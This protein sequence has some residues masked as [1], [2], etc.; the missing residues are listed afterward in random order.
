MR[1]GDDWSRFEVEA[2]VASYRDM[3]RLELLGEKFNKS[4]RNHALQMVTGRG[5]GAIEFKHQNISAVLNQAGFPYIVGYKPLSKFQ[6]LLL[7]VVTQQILEDPEINALAANAV[8]RREFS[9]EKP[10]DL[11]SIK[12]DPPVGQRG[13]FKNQNRLNE[14][15]QPR[16]KRNYVEIEGRNSALGLAGEE[17]VMSFEHERLWR[18]GQRR[19]AERIEHSSI[20]KG[21]HLGYDIHSFEE[22]GKDR[23][24]EVKT[25][26]FGPMTPFFASRNEVDI[27]IELSDNYQLYRVFS[28]TKEAKLFALE[29]AI[30]S[31]CE[32]TP[33][34]FS[35]VPR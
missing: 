3:L 11:L 35:A 24:I 12:V 34:M 31:K 5:R 21:D 14:T 7:D 17:L 26:Q 1:D 25:T 20:V 19:L 28:F 30:G 13:Y 32:L 29:G 2:A 10:K 6:G 9:S 16:S 4:Q 23:L 33:I 8:A 18:S 27:S 15:E 22:N